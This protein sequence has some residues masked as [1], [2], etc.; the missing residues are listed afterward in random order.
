MC[1]RTVYTHQIR[2]NKLSS[3]R[4]KEL[5][6]TMPFIPCLLHNTVVYALT[7]TLHVH[8]L[9][10]A[11]AAVPKILGD[12]PKRLTVRNY[13]QLLCTQASRKVPQKAVSLQHKCGEEQRNSY[14]S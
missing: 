2:S 13:Q 6:Y 12:A 4:V 3:N 1:P 10:I 8:Q 11:A 14:A 9:F 5:A 7:V